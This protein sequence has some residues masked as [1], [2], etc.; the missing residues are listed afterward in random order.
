MK[1]IR[2]IIKKT[3]H[4][5]QLSLGA[6]NSKIDDF[7][8]CPPNIVLDLFRLLG[9]PYSCTTS[10]NTPSGHLERVDVGLTLYLQNLT[11]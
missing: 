9:I 2:K 7:S 6:T 10:G 1:L 4:V 3:L 8:I 5:F 11:F